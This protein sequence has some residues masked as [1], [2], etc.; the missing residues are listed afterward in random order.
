MF[1][2]KRQ[3]TGGNNTAAAAN[4]AAAA[5]MAQRLH[6][7][8]IPP[9]AAAHGRNS[10]PRLADR[11]SVVSLPGY[12]GTHADFA[13]FS[14]RSVAAQLPPPSDAVAA[15]AVSWLQG[16]TAGPPE[17]TPTPLGIDT[18]SNRT[19]A[20]AGQPLHASGSANTAEIARDRA[21]FPPDRDFG[22]SLYVPAAS[23]S[24]DTALTCLQPVQAY[25]PYGVVR[26]H[27][28]LVRA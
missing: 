4:A 21:S 10:W 18:L 1:Q 27:A 26:F 13:D 19:A 11:Q 5:A 15:A 22:L 3:R 24:R 6:A 28:Q 9:A 7:T 25:R 17:D 23:A 2:G 12:F 8:V 16:F 14:G 20:L